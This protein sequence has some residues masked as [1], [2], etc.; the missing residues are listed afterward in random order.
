MDNVEVASRRLSERE[1]A[2]Y[3]GQVNVRTLQHWRLAGRGPTYHK[4]GKRV[5]YDVRDLDAFLAAGRV[6]PTA[7]VS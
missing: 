3:L 2:Q 5:A 4:L 7:R 6:E 1:A